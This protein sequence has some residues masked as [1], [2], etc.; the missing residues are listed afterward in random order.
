MYARVIEAVFASEDDEDC[1]NDDK[2]TEFCLSEVDVASCNI[3]F[4][5]VGLQYKG[6]IHHGS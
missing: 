2:I 6:R 4:D 5:R 3:V 1:D